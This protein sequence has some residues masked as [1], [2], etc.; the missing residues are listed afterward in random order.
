M[1]ARAR[2]SLATSAKHALNAFDDGAPTPDSML[3]VYL[4]TSV[5][6]IIDRAYLG[7]FRANAKELRSTVT[8]KDTDNLEAAESAISLVET[9]L[10]EE[11]TVN[12]PG[13]AIFANKDRVVEVAQLP[14]RPEEVLHWGPR[15]VVEP[16]REALDEFERIAVVLF[17]LEQ[18]RYFSIFL[19]EIEHKETFTDDV[20]GKQ[21]T[22]GWYGLS[23]KNYQRHHDDRVLKHAKRTAALLG[24]ELAVRPFDRLFLAGPDEAVAVLRH[25]LPKRIA[26]RLAGVLG[27][28]HFAT[29]A[30][31]LA[32]ALVAGEE[33]ELAREIA[34]VDALFENRSDHVVLGPENTF[35][36][37]FIGRV[38]RLF[39][40]RDASREV[41]KCTECGRLTGL[42]PCPVC[43]GAVEPVQDAVETAI[44]LAVGQGARIEIV[45]GAAGA[46]LLTAGGFGAWTRRSEH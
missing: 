3:S 11:F 13:V 2:M 26:Q 7:S 44:E 34:E 37:L 21:A 25:H 45:N 15:A 22:G 32:A 19:G 29:D 36:A 1:A 46:R 23:Q 12:G 9:F 39:V 43:T 38:D 33:A 6:R 28:E 24:S 31:V 20:P 14:F 10:T 40:A 17:D 35:H 8:L 27:L 4:D 41:G 16:L 30:E 42:D 18:T 5:T